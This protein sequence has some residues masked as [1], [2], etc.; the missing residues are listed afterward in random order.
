MIPYFDYRPAYRRIKPEIDAALQRVLDSGR[1]ILGPEVEAFEH[2]FAAF[3]GA[4]G[5]VGVNSGTDALIL[6]LRALGL[7]AGDEVITTA[8]CG[9]PPVA[10]IRAAGAQPRFVDVRPD[11]L[12]IDPGGLE[13]ARSP[14]TRAVLAVH[15]YG[16]PA[17]LD[18]LRE[19]ARRHG[20]SLVEDCA[21]AHGATYRG[22]TVGT[23]GDAGC[24]SFYPTKNLGAYGDGG[25]VVSPDLDLL[26]RV[27]RLRM[28]GFGSDRH[29][30]VEGLNSRL[31]EMQ[32]AIL[33]VKL[34]HLAEDNA[35]RRRLA[36][37]YL[38]RLR[39]AAG[40]RLP[41]TVA[42]REHVYHLFVVQATDRAG[43]IEGLERDAVGYGIHYP[44]PVHLM[45]AYGFLGLGRGALPVSE[46]AS[47]RVLSLP[48]YPGLETT[49]QDR[50][51]AAVRAAT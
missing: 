28:Y 5:A 46:Q 23:L 19:F 45:Q 12:L 15:L 3:L 8:N 24:F 2:E 49:A 44:E 31:D 26:E 40:L 20:L 29:A 48:L 36:E 41:Q 25:A 17:D 11:T 43:L 27:R 18:P 30:Y 34:A 21:Q 7:G 14:R 35:E 13:Q 42:N 4:P 1:L 50:V 37:R 51:V 39:G 32:A 38:N 47:R 10:A 16:Q 6:V 9:V 22:A 33:R